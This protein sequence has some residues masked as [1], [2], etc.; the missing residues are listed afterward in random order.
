GISIA[1]GI[2]CLAIFVGILNINSVQSSIY[3]FLMMLLVLACGIGLYLY[4]RKGILV[5]IKEM[6]EVAGRLAE[7]DLETQFDIKE[8]DDEIGQLAKAFQNMAE[9][10]KTQAKAV[11]KIAEGNL[12]IGLEIVSEKDILGRNIN[13]MR[14]N[15]QALIDQLLYLKGQGNIG[16]H[17]E[18]AEIGFLK[19]SYAEILEGVNAILDYLGDPLNNLAGYF[20]MMAEGDFPDEI[21]TSDYKGEFIG[22]MELVNR[23]RNNIYTIDDEIKTLTRMAD[24]GNLSFR[25]DAGKVPGEY[26]LILGGVNHMLDTV[27]APIGEASTV[28]EA[29]A[30]GDLGSRVNGD[31]QG[32]HGAIKEAL[33][34]MGETIGGYVKEISE[35]LNEMASNNLDVAI[36]RDYRG[37]FSRIKESLDNII[38]KFN[39]IMGDIHIAA[40]QVETAS[41][42]VADSSQ[43]LSQGAA[44]QASSV[45]EIS[46]SMTQ[47]GEQTRQNAENANKANEISVDTRRIAKEGNRKM[48]EMVK[49]M[50]AI[51][52]ASG[53]ISKVI[54]VIDG[55]AFQT[56]IL[57]LNAAVEAARA[58]EHGK[59]FAVVAEEVRNLAARSATAANE[60]TE[61]IND[62]LEKVKK[63]TELALDTSYALE[64]IVAGVDEAVE[65]V[66]QIAEASNEQASAVA[67]ISEG[68][69]QVTN[70]TQINT[71][72]AEESASASEDMT[73]QAKTLAEL[74]NRFKLRKE[75]GQVF[76]PR[77]RTFQ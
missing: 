63:G 3:I 40:N 70:V 28:L 72:T 1:M 29:M 25:T 20:T 39:D 69:N 17:S 65:I 51:D 10:L 48:D 5:P 24:I 62:S 15:L 56:N 23:I 36:E 11:Q 55:I 16:N 71:A 35:V 12:D 34:S 26:G 33:N 54:K 64:R 49:A 42:Q 32:D 76:L 67:E 73:S 57:A 66:G 18:R 61:M 50:E 45:E 74:A 58:G 52:V 77:E 59:G 9:K 13:F 2:I 53:N 8:T 22:F 37:D 43:N 7:G 30:D 27:I 46:A 68:I 14:D 60:T 6:T 75:T 21:D 47:V 31:Y 4:M 19:G 38:G 44:E 41:A